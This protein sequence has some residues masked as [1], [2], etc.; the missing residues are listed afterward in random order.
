MSSL[1]LPAGMTSGG[2]PVGIELDALAGND[3][4]LLSMGRAVERALGPIPA[5]IGL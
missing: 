2:L 1:V 5:P 4:W 3:R